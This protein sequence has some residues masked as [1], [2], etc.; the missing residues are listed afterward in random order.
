[1]QRLLG[2]PATAECQ[3]G[4]HGSEGIPAQSG[5]R[6][7][8]LWCE[9]RTVQHV[10][11]QTPTRGSKHRLLISHSASTALMKYHRLEICFLTVP[12]ARSPRPKCNH[13]WIPG[14]TSFLACRG[15][16][17]CCVLTWQRDRDS[18][19]FFFFPYKDNNSL[20]QPPP[21]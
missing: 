11:P 17:S 16:S 2:N 5:G 6:Q 1:M 3:W 15:L 12:E 10:L 7:G 14:R 21:L 13:S 20:M 8:C 9:L 19:G 18:S 4:S